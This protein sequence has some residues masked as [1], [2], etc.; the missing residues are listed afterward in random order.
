MLSVETMNLCSRE[1]SL[2]RG[3]SGVKFRSAPQPWLPIGRMPLLAGCIHGG[4]WVVADIRVTQ[5]TV[6]VG[7]LNLKGDDV[8]INAPV[9]IAR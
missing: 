8:V 9:E 3:A 7:V 1:L 2:Q 4:G 5:G 6:S